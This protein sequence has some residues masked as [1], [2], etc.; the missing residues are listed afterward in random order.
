MCQ[1]LW[2]GIWGVSRFTL[3]YWIIHALDTQ[4]DATAADNHWDYLRRQASLDRQRRLAWRIL[5]GE[6]QHLPWWARLIPDF[7][8]GLLNQVTEIRNAYPQ[9]LERVNPEL[10]RLFRLPRWPSP[11]G[12]DRYLVLGI[13]S[14]YPG[15]G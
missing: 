15:A 14:V 13:C 8:Q 6:V 9:L 11:G 2:D 1:T 5:S 4:I 12:A 3:P 10:L 7:V